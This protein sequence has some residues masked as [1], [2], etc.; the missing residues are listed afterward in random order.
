VCVCVCVRVRAC[1]RVCETQYY[2]FSS[3]QIE[4]NRNA[5]IDQRKKAEADL[6]NMGYILDDSK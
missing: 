6:R 2:Y 3:L 1:V 4:Y 5:A